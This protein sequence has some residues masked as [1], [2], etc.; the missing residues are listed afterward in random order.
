V[1]LSPAVR[2]QLRLI[3]RLPSG[4]SDAAPVVF[5]HGAWHGAW[6]WDA[7]FLPYF[8]RHGHPAYAFDLRGHGGSAGTGPLRRTRIDDY[9]ADL[10]QVV[11]GLAP[12]PVLVG[13]SMGGLI[14]QRYLEAHPGGAGVLLASLPP[15]GSRSVAARLAARHPRTML[16][17]VA[18]RSLLPLVATPQ[19]AREAFFSP[20]IDDRRLAEYVARLQDESFR[21]FLD[22]VLHKGHP[23]RVRAPMLV[24]G[25]EHDTFLTH[26]DVRATA[27]AF[28]TTATF[29]P[30][31]HDLMLDDGWQDVADHILRWLARRPA[32]A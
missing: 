18:T 17:V 10:E 31:A 13:H 22:I 15:A 19:R 12:G 16:K 23:R 4:A 3:S 27:R 8:A 5:V 26:A 30:A 1:S 29:F 20:G 9:V 14:V 24:I 7:H 21:A 28:H 2:G 11:S 32:L 6:C 25:A